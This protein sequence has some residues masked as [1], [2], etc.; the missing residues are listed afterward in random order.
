[1]QFDVFQTI[2]YDR[3]REGYE[4]TIRTRQCCWP[5]FFY[6]QAKIVRK[7]LIPTVFDFFMTFLSSKNDVNVHSKSNKQIWITRI[8]NTVTEIFGSG[9]GNKCRNTACNTGEWTLLLVNST[10]Q[11]N[12]WQFSWMIWSLESPYPPPHNRQCF[13]SFYSS[14]NGSRFRGIHKWKAENRSSPRYGRHF[15]T[16]KW[17]ATAGAH[18]EQKKYRDR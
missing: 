6:H 5:G 10:Q 14:E 9:S 18:T 11:G 2:L 16:R 8:R 7:T 15:S 17:Y 12:S 13:T 4:L 1:M 3:I